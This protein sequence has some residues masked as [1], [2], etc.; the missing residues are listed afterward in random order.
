MSLPCGCGALVALLG[1]VAALLFL[2]DEGPAL[3]ETIA[4]ELGIGE[5]GIVTEVLGGTTRPSGGDVSPIDWAGG[6]VEPGEADYAP[7]ATAPGE[8]EAESAEAITSSAPTTLSLSDGTRLDLPPTDSPVAVRLSRQTN[9]IA[10]EHAVLETS[11]SMRVLEYDPNAVDGA[12]IPTLTIPA[13]ELGGLDLAA[14]NVAR[15]GPRWVDGFLVDDELTYLTATPTGDGGLRVVDTTTAALAA[16]WGSLYEASAGKTVAGLAQYGD[17]RF[18]TIRYVP[19][20]FQGHLEWYV[21]PRLVRMIPDP[22]APALRRPAV[23]T[24]DREI[25]ERPVTNI[26][27]LVHGHNEEEW[28]GS[29]APSAEEPW[30][31]AYKQEAWTELYRTFLETQGDRVIAWRSTSSSTP[32]TA[33]P[34]AL[35]SGA[36]SLGETLAKALRVGALNDGYQIKR[37]REAKMPANLYVGAH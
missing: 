30:K 6:D 13:R 24:A 12:F 25:L 29:S 36:V 14:V 22:D 8:A 15:V 9:T 16:A 31:Y 35:S 5:T 11:G 17:G 33:P 10:M 28:D 7:R 18:G 26:V 21:H 20:S 19:M 27:V 32:P 37:L 34:T 1:V 4:R 3:V 2:T 23:P